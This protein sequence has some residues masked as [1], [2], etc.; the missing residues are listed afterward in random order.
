MQNPASVG[1][2]LLFV[3]KIKPMVIPCVRARGAIEPTE[4]M[5]CSSDVP[6]VDTHLLYS[7][8]VV[9]SQLSFLALVEVSKDKPSR[10][11]SGDGKVRS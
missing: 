9:L 4:Y 5:L 8:C 11:N 7:V 1:M 3:T 10:R 6:F 2:Q